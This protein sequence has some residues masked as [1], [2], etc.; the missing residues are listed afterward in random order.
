MFS[1]KERKK[2]IRKT[3]I[4]RMTDSLVTKG[5]GGPVRWPGQQDSDSIPLQATLAQRRRH[6]LGTAGQK[7]QH[8]APMVI[9]FI[10]PSLPRCWLPMTGQSLEIPIRAS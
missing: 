6:L 10:A 1:I 3:E 2:K 8:V 9:I 5:S 7:E 4:D